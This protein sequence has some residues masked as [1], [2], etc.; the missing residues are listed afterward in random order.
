M[1][2]EV[3]MILYC[4]KEAIF[5]TLGNQNIGTQNPQDQF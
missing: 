2:S 4:A 1:E 3:L 5:N